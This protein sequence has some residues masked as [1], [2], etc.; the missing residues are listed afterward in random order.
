MPPISASKWPVFETYE[1]EHDSLPVGSG[2]IVRELDLSDE[3]LQESM[4]KDWLEAKNIL[5]WI[6]L[7]G[8]PWPPHD[9][10]ET[11]S[12]LSE[13]ARAMGEHWRRF[14]KAKAN[15][16][17]LEGDVW[18]LCDPFFDPRLPLMMATEPF[19]NEETGSGEFLQRLCQPGTSPVDVELWMAGGG[20]NEKLIPLGQDNFRRSLADENIL[21]SQYSKLKSSAD[22]LRRSGAEIERFKQSRPATIF[23]GFANLTYECPAAKFKNDPLGTAQEYALRPLRDYMEAGL[24]SLSPNLLI[25]RDEDGDVHFRPGWSVASPFMAL[26]L[27]A[28]RQLTRADLW[29]VCPNPRCSILYEKTRSNRAS[30][31]APRCREYVKRQRRAQ[32]EG[33]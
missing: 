7:Y 6:Q 2:A 3:N 18:V 1:Q 11:Y 16:A 14:K 9:P 21:R 22:R 13:S 12:D 20:F 8:L 30:C 24:R 29:E 31:G 10:D 32:R 19:F 27:A 25:E 5:D 4:L 28:Y 17:F 23:I 15:P 33:R 26:C